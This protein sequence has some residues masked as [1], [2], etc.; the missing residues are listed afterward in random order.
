MAFKILC[1]DGYSTKGVDV[2]EKH[3]SF[4]V[5]NIKAL[6]HEELL[7]KIPE[8]HGLI[9]RSSSDVSADVIAAGKNLKIIA[10]AGVGT[11]NIDIAAATEKGI[12]VVNAP[13]GNTITTAEHTFAM[14]MSAARKIPQAYKS[15]QE[16]KWDKKSFEGVELKGKVLGLV[17]LGRIGREVAKRAQAF[18][19]ETIGFDPYLASEAAERANIKLMT[20]DELYVQADFI[21]VHTPLTEE[22]K[23]LISKPQMAKMKK[24]AILI[25]CARGGIINEAD[26]AEALKAG[27]VAG[28]ALDVFTDE[29]IKDNIFK[30]LPNCIT[31][32]HLGAS[33]KEAQISVAIET[34]NAVV[35]NLAMNISTNAVNAPAVPR[36]IM[37]KAKVYL[38]LAEKLGSLISQ[39]CKCKLKEI[40]VTVSGDKVSQYSQIISLYVVK[41]ILSPI[42]EENVTLVNIPVISKRRNITLATVIAS[43]ADEMGQMVEVKLVTEGESF[44]VWGRVN[45]AGAI[46]ITRFQEYYLE[47]EPQG[48]MLF[49]HN[50]DRPGILGKICTLLGSEAINIAELKNIRHEKGKG[51]MT[52]IHLDEGIPSSVLEKLTALSEVTNVLQVKL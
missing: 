49:I 46:Q 45:Y 38:E 33:T 23:G 39:A 35:D 51:A 14:L 50:L 30:D 29:P 7:Q 8:F 19:M 41:S 40:R 18:G 22:T 44:E 6:T 31:T 34:A 36:E 11:D 42:L 16:G 2:L 27:A 20:L 5:T 17:G 52:V 47:I 12:V 48:N 9:V 32:P 15:M 1:T 28:A 3:G 26:L 21:T 4:Q 25:N 43:E 10:R 37:T 24:T 13:G